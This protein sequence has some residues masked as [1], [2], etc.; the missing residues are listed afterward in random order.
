MEQ[1]KIEEYKY[2]N[3]QILNHQGLVIQVFTFSII[4][5]VAILGLALNNY[6]GEDKS[7]YALLVAFV[8]MAIII[9][10]AFFLASTRADIFRLGAFIR[11]I[12]ESGQDPGYETLLEKKREGTGYIKSMREAFSYVMVT[13]WL[14]FIVCLV[15]FVWGLSSLQLW[16]LIFVVVLAFIMLVS[17]SREF[18]SIPTDK[19]RKQFEKEWKEV[20]EQ[21][22]KSTN[23]PT[24]EG[25]DEKVDQLLQNIQSPNSQIMDSLSAVRRELS[26]SQWPAFFISA[27]ATSFGVGLAV[28][29]FLVKSG[30]LSERHRIGWIL[31]IIFG[32]L[33][34]LNGILGSIPREYKTFAQLRRV[35]TWSNICSNWYLV[36]A[37]GFLIAALVL[38]W[39]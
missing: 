35:V 31:F 39:R 36:S 22:V 14:I 20:L 38:L 32:L 30:T 6:F 23:K 26:R 29:G 28:L 21:P 5:S 13:Y 16:Y 7:K 2:L 8:P 15:F 10:C 3:R 18:F 1:R 37:I 9:P 24:H 12:H 34:A 25:T 27:G 17:A 11:V 19:R 4:A 33:L